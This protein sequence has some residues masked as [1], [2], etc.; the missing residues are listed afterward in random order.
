MCPLKYYF[1]VLIS[2]L[3][4][5]TQS[6]ALDLFC[7]KN[8][9]TDVAQHSEQAGGGEFVMANGLMGSD[10]NLDDLF[11]LYQDDA[12]L[13]RKV[14]EILLSKPPHQFQAT[15]QSASE[16]EPKKTIIEKLFPNRKLIGRRI[17]LV[18]NE[19]VMS[20]CV[21]GAYPSFGDVSKASAGQ[22]K[23]VCF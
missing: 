14:A 17:M 10:L 22:L 6:S 1:L 15:N 7:Q 18:W 3:L 21:G 20:S 12:E 19:A 5:S 4:F 2:A 23:Q 16:L 11:R 8:K 9:S 13:S